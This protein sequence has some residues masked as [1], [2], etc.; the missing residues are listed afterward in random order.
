MSPLDEAEAF[1]KLLEKGAGF[2]DIAAMYDRSIA[3]IK[4][5]VRLC[6]LHDG[7]KAM[8]REGRLKLSGA[9]LLASLPAESQAKFAKKHADKSINHWDI[10]NF[11]H[12]TQ[13]SV[14]ARIADGRCEKCGSRTRNAEPGL[15]EDFNGLEDVCFDQDCY[16][17]KWKKLIEG[18]VAKEKE[19]GSQAENNV[20]LGGNIPEFLPRKTESVVLGGVEYKLLSRQKH[21]WKE[22]SKKAAKGTAWLVDAPY[23]S[24]DVK[25]RRV[26]Y[27]AYERPDCGGSAPSDPM[28]EYMADQLPEIEEEDLKAAAE[29]VEGKYRSV[30]N[31]AFTVREA[32]LDA[33]I[34]RRLKE[35][36]RANLAA[37]YLIA[38]RGGE[39]AQ[40]ERREIDP[41]R[42]ETFAAIFGHDGVAK[43]SDIP[44][45][46]LIQKVFL[47]LIATGANPGDLPDLND[48]ESE[49]AEAE[50]SLF[51]KFAQMERSEYVAMYKNSLAEALKAAGGRTEKEAGE[52]GWRR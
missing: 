22:A 6:D 15:F 16:A 47:F 52:R 28:K 37:E 41:E 20:I 40:G 23:D 8:F 51:W 18:L 12:Q 46:P 5:R 30:W 4:H 38:R 48:S 45:E 19:G 50:A 3:G 31:L 11:I 26:A 34:A 43:P 32:L 25:V 36:S 1:K 35:E 10:S 2:K 33:I 17:G 49:W 21:T 13:R 29:K 7:L 42:A 39:G 27:K 14:I 9:A 44:A 24:T